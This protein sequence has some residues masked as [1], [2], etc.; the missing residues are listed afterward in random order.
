MY[1][2]R[3]VAARAGVDAKRSAAHRTPRIE[4]KERGSGRMS[5]GGLSDQEMPHE[6]RPV[7]QIASVEAVSVVESDVAEQRNLE[8]E[9]DAH[10]HLQ[11][12]GPHLLQQVPGVS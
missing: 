11:V 6:L 5:E 9:P 10:A 7:A 2:M 3:D 1:P 8:P 4:P 12:E